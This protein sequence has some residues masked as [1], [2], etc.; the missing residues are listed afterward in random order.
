MNGPVKLSQFTVRP[1]QDGQYERR[2]D[3]RKGDLVVIGEHLHAVV[4]RDKNFVVFTCSETGEIVFLS[5]TQIGSMQKDGEFRTQSL[6]PN[7]DGSSREWVRDR[8]SLSSSQEREGKRRLDYVTCA[9]RGNPEQYGPTLIDKPSR[10]RSV[11]VP[12]IRA[13]AQRRDEKPPGFSTVLSWVDIWIE[14]GTRDGIACLVPNFEFRGNRVR[15]DEDVIAAGQMAVDHWLNRKVSVVDAHAVLSVHLSTNATSKLNPSTGEASPMPRVP[16]RRTLS[17]WCS[18]VPA[19]TRDYYRIGP[20][21][22]RKEHKVYDKRPKPTQPYEEIEADHCIL[23]VRVL[24][25]HRRFILGRP[26]VILFIDRATAMIVGYSISLEEPSYASL[27]EG[28]ANTML[29]KDLSKFSDLDLGWWNPHG[30]IGTLILDF[31]MENRSS[32]LMETANELGFTVRLMRPASPWE[33]GQIERTFRSLNHAV[34]HRVTGATMSNSVER[35]KYDDLGEPLLTIDDVERLLVEW[36][37][38]EHNIS[39]TRSVPMR[40]SD[41]QP[42]IPGT[43]TI[44]L[45]NWEKAAGSMMMAIGSV[46]SPEVLEAIVGEKKMCTIGNSGIEWDGITYSDAGLNI[47]RSMERK[48]ASS[49][50]KKQA[51]V[52]LRNPNDIGKISV[53]DPFSPGSVI[54]VPACQDHRDYAEGITRRMH[55]LFRLDA[56]LETKA[57][58][59][60]EG[61]DSEPLIVRLTRAKA[62][63]SAALLA[64]SANPRKKRATDNTTKHLRAEETRRSRSNLKT[65]RTIENESVVPSYE[66]R[67]RVPFENAKSDPPRRPSIEVVGSI[68]TIEQTANETEPNS[69]TEIRRR[70]PISREEHVKHLM[71]SA[72]HDD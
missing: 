6:V 39:P 69:E 65:S 45:K 11:L 13:V 25:A 64:A 72:S 9:L 43:E 17:R 56:N 49:E 32:S 21:Y 8:R 35:K 27:L 18:S 16:S 2:Y 19:Y 34:F 26:V 44:P 55:D 10:A 1:P 58:M 60:E 48:G 20:A 4:A 66:A 15:W 38:N 14:K 5:D 70:S 23:D 54:E 24:D 40:L 31:A 28:L 68:S 63:R 7:R 41:D 57:A 22:A 62:K 37:V 61:T 67:D 51:Y 29:P 50:K 36:I 42:P 59:T 53:I 33:K 52:C 3:L 46:P 71:V 12:I 30:K 47:L